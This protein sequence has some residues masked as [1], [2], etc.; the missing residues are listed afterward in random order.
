MQDKAKLKACDHLELYL[1]ACEQ[2]YGG[3][4]HADCV[5]R[6]LERFFKETPL[7]WKAH[8]LFEEIKAGN[9][10]YATDNLIKEINECL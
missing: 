9:V 2:V 1:W 4:K 10:E 3:N 7:H 6:E 8:A 5:R